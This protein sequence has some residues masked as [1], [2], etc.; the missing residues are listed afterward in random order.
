MIEPVRHSPTDSGLADILK[1]IQT[2][3]AYMSARI[4]PPSSMHRLG[5]EDIAGQCD[6][7]EVWSIGQPPVACILMKIKLDALYIGKLAVSEKWRRTGLARNLVVLAE[8]RARHFGLSWLELESRVELL[9]NH[10]VFASLGFRKTGEGRHTGYD[11]PTYIIMRKPVR[12]DCSYEDKGTCPGH[13]GGN[14]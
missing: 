7:G 2:S 12:A 4:D 10:A 14:D 9:D 6:V 11:R 1:L 13:P 3:F 8:D 5:L